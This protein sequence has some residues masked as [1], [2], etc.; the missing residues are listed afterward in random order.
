MTSYHGFTKLI[1]PTYRDGKLVPRDVGA[2][3]EYI[4]RQGK[5][6]G[7]DD[8]VTHFGFAVGGVV[9]GRSYVD[10]ALFASRRPP[11]ARGQTAFHIVHSIWEQDTSE[12]AAAA[13]RASVEAHCAKFCRGR[14][15]VAALHVLHG[16]L[17]AHVLVEAY[18]GRRCL[19]WKPHVVRGWARQGF[20][21]LVVSSAGLGKRGTKIYTGPKAKNKYAFCLTAIR[22]HGLVSLIKTGAIRQGRSDKHGNLKTIVYEGRHLKLEVL[23]V[24]IARQ[25]R[26]E[27]GRDAGHAT[28]ILAH[29]KNLTISLSAWDQAITRT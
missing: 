14:S 17:H 9:T 20:T 1:P 3:L 16:R 24:I 13:L 25:M 21:P 8:V 27:A 19:G 23:Q 2:S 29:S 18:D 6:D 12:Q 22:D 11:G 7:L 4:Y 10:E 5:H 28:A 15:W 26:S